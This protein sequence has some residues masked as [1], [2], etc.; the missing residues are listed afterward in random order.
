MTIRTQAEDTRDALANG[1]AR[2]DRCIYFHAK[3]A[4]R[5]D[6]WDD[7][8]K[9]RRRPPVAL[10]LDGYDDIVT[11]WPEVSPFRWCGEWDSGK[12]P[13]EVRLEAEGSHDHETDWA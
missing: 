4:G 13:L 1:V 9:C 5:D 2:C 7:S 6:D 11:A 10:T 12:F 8:G 3:K